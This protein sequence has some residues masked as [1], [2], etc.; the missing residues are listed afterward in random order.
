M[1]ISISVGIMTVGAQCL[2]ILG[3]DENVF[4]YGIVASRGMV[5]MS[6]CIEV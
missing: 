6:H 4:V 3:V 1:I 5:E 2:L